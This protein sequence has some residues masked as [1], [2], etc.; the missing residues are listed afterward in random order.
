MREYAEPTIEFY[1]GGQARLR[2]CDGIELAHLVYKATSAGIEIYTCASA[3]EGKAVKQAYSKGAEQKAWHTCDTDTSKADPNLRL[4]LAKDY[5]DYI[6]EH[7]PEQSTESRAGACA[8]DTLSVSED[9]RKL[10]W[11]KD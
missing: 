6:K 1:A 3:E 4:A 5:Y 7:K 11:H 2:G 10:S 8:W 9:L